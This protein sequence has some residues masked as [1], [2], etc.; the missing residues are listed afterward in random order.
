MRLT[1]HDF[2]CTVP[3]CGDVAR[4]LR[5]G[6][7]GQAKIEYPKFTVLVDGQ[8]AGLEVAVDD[9]GGVD[10]LEAAQHL[11]DQ[12]LHVIVGK[13][14]RS[15]DVVQVGSHEMSH[16]V[17]LL[18][19]FQGVAMVEGVEQSDDVLVVHVLQQPKLAKRPL[20]MRRGL[21]G[22][23][24]LLNGHFRVCNCI[25]SGAERLIIE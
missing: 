2:R 4:H 21:K 3:A 15:N 1:Q 9:A 19:R 23:I 13:A 12:E 11:V 18:E 5:L 10:V 7:P 22:T 20:G 16:E 8:V 17:D 6:G 25:Y 24:Q 14:L